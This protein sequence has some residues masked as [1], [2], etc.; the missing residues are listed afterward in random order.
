MSA[1]P[2]LP[3][4]AVLIPDWWTPEQALAVFELLND[5]RDTLWTIHG[6]QIQALLQREQGSIT[7]D[8]Q[9]GEPNPDD[10]SF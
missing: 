1:R 5:L 9:H 8:L 6:S 10:Q 4:A 2:K 7:S 3:A